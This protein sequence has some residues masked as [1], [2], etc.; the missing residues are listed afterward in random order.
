MLVIRLQRVGRRNHAEFRVVV[1]EHTMGPKSATY[2]EIVGNY[3]PH[4]N[5]IVFKE[6]RIKHWMSVGAKPSDTV[7]NLL[8]KEGIVEGKKRNVL[9][10]KSAPAPEPKEEAVKEEVVTEEAA[11]ETPVEEEAKEEAAAA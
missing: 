4:N 2:S 1:C 10:K 9:P 5:Q 8:V 3:N 11:E 6:D 7:H